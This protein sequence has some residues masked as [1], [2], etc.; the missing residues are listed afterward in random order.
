M[1]H[2]GTGFDLASIAQVTRLGAPFPGRESTLHKK[3]TAFM[4]NDGLVEPFESRLR[5]GLDRV[6]FR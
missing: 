5:L 6:R 1:K 3:K 2:D 4:V